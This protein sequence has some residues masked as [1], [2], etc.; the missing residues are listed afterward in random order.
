MKHIKK[1]LTVAVA[2]CLLLGGQAHG[3]AAQA[4]HGAKASGGFGGSGGGTSVISSIKGLDASSLANVDWKTQGMEILNKIEAEAKN[5]LEAIKDGVT[6]IEKHIKEMS[7]QN[8]GSLS[9]V[10][11]G[12]VK[13]EL[14]LPGG[15]SH[16]TSDTFSGILFI[17]T[18]TLPDIIPSA[19]KAIFSVMHLN[20]DD[21][22]SKVIETPL[23]ITLHELF[24][25]DS[26][27]KPAAEATGITGEGTNGV[28]VLASTPA[29][30]YFF[31]VALLAKD[32][33]TNGKDGRPLIDKQTFGT[34]LLILTKKL[35]KTLGP[36]ATFSTVLD[37]IPQPLEALLSPVKGQIQKLWSEISDL[38]NF[39]FNTIAK[40]PT[41]GDSDIKK[42][43]TIMGA[44][45][46]DYYLNYVSERGLFVQTNGGKNAWA[47]L[48]QSHD[49]KAFNAAFDAYKKAEFLKT[50]AGKQATDAF[51]QSQD[52]KAYDAAIK[53]GT[54]KAKQAA[55]DRFIAL[56]KH[57]SGYKTLKAKI[58]ST[59]SFLNPLLDPLTLNDIF[60]ADSDISPQ[61]AA[62]QQAGS[63][64]LDAALSG[65][66][67]GDGSDTSGDGSGD[68]SSDGTTGDGSSDGTTGDGSDA[69]ADG[70]SDGSGDG[71]T[72]DGSSD[73]TTTDGSDA[74]TDGSDASSGDGSADPSSAS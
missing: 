72:D 16:S 2:G 51:N 19:A 48:N 17:L 53:A 39:D 34:E 30:E 11:A 57:L 38:I 22:I 65:D 62:N 25:T 63:D 15:P 8:S 36:K 14:Q 10:N 56:G 68:G 43:A 31:R 58:L 21:L 70:T 49:L 6:G 50:D 52:Q 9:I 5:Q 27:F 20:V 41:L 23:E 74:S 32:M 18:N 3:Q 12:A 40:L 45:G 71:T 66:S 7:Y 64:A 37:E 28:Y 59:L 44:I 26:H 67:S 55:T 60:P 42:I 33:K 1:W 13:F 47:S 61:E 69:S 73:G 46:L 35:M 54:G 29:M 24:K 4:A